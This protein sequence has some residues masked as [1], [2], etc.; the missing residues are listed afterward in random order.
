MSTATVAII[1]LAILVVLAAFL[2]NQSSG[3]TQDYPYRQT[4]G[5]LSKAELSFFGVLRQAVGDNGIV[6]AKARIADVLAV[7]RG[8]SNSRRQTAFNKIQ[9]KHFDFVVCASDTAKP[10]VAVELD[11]SSHK[12]K[13]RITRD[14]FVNGAAEAASLPLLR[15]PAKNAYPIA[16]LKAQLAPHFGLSADSDLETP[17]P[18]QS[19]KPPTCPKCGSGMVNRHGKTGVLAGKEFWGCEQYPMCRSVLP[20]G[21]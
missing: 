12:Q 8:L 10:L 1:V 20:I 16:Q 7:K 21:A 11:D 15:V 4:D 17:E 19:G 2:K 13:S 14:T 5:F 9:S 3:G 18:S 6:F